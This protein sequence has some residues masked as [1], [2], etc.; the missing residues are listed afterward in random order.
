MDGLFQN[1][2]LNCIKYFAVDSRKSKNK[3]SHFDNNIFNC[4]YLFL[5]EY[6]S[7]RCTLDSTSNRSAI[8]W[9]F[10]AGYSSKKWSMFVL[11]EQINVLQYHFKMKFLLV[12]ACLC[13]WTTQ[14]RQPTL[15]L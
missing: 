11:C 12:V 15:T 3:N 10:K 2:P 1:I 9:V 8:R 6:E 5:V 7:I 13:V 14:V 4:I